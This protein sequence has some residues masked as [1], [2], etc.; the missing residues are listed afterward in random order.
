M[1]L[2]NQI[3]LYLEQKHIIAEED[4]DIVSFGMEH[5]LITLTNIVIFLIMGFLLHMFW[6]TVFFLLVFS[7]V[8]RYA[9]GY[10]A[11]TRWRCFLYSIITVGTSLFLIKYIYMNR[12]FCVISSWIAGSVIVTNSPVED[13][14]K[15]LNAYEVY[16]YRK[17]A[18]LLSL[19]WIV[20]LNILEVM[21]QDIYVYI[22]WIALVLVMI[23]LVMGRVK[24][25]C[26]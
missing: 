24:N 25:Q 14:N 23:L 1:K 2:S 18:V 17:R 13:R 19:M 16:A 11:P 5:M 9:G 8:R 6:E 3:S 4:R 26:R 20:L 12:V 22:I 21:K 10:H 7:S 15:P